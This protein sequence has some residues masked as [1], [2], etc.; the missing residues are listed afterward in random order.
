M[1][2]LKI[3]WPLFQRDVAILGYE[4]IP[5]RTMGSSH[6]GAYSETIKRFMSAK[7]EKNFSGDFG[8]SKFTKHNL[9]SFKI[10][11]SSYEDFQE[12]EEFLKTQNEPYP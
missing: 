5:T 9:K 12:Y 4:L 1:D 3:I 11:F 8:V 7:D 2:N 6:V 10:I